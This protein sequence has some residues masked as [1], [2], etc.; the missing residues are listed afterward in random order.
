MTSNGYECNLLVLSNLTYLEWVSVNCDEP[1]LNYIACITARTLQNNVTVLKYPTNLTCPLNSFIM[2]NI[3]YFFVW[4]NGY[5][6][7]VSNNH[8]PI[9]DDASSCFIIFKAASRERLKFLFKSSIIGKMQQV[10]FERIWL[11]TYQKEISVDINTAEGYAVYDSQSTFIQKYNSI[12]IYGNREFIST[13]FICD[14]IDDCKDFSDEANCKCKIFKGFCKEICDDSHCSCSPLYHRLTN[15]TCIPYTRNHVTVTTN[16]G[17]LT[18]RTCKENRTKSTI[19]AHD[20]IPDCGLF[21]EVEPILK[22][23]DCSSEGQLPCKFSHTSCYNVSEICIY[24]L[25]N[26]VFSPFRN[27]ANLQD[28]QLF[29]CPDKYKCP[30]YYCISWNLICVGKWDCPHGY[31]EHNNLKCGQFRKC[32]NMYRCR[33]SQTC[34]HINDICDSQN[35]CPSSDEMLC[36]IKASKC[37]W[38]CTCLGFAFYCHNA[39]IDINGLETLPY[40]AY[41]LVETSI[42]TH[43]FVD[44][45]EKENGILLLNISFNK[46][47]VLCPYMKSFKPLEILD[48]S[49]N[50]VWRIF[51]SCFKNLHMLCVIKLHNNQ[52]SLIESGA[53]YNLKIL[54]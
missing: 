7:D 44:L 49:H 42:Q 39:Q 43:N 28:C 11:N 37:P 3:C 38:Q 45:L 29:E 10:T 53:F 12:F 25:N 2:Y 46:I 18:N 30:G 17:E 23:H 47:I 52:L 51:E 33:N 40:I 34:M 27:G 5:N 20:L 35:D 22:N 8:S 16:Q 6:S 13:L 14:N 41:Y 1:L 31:D 15:R 4:F 48:I 21:P 54:R 24:R 26:N 32:P 50:L 9:A 36:E 19:L